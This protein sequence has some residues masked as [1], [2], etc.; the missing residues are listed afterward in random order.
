MGGHPE[1]RPFL[2]RW[3]VAVTLGETLGF[4][5]V[6]VVGASLASSPAPAGVVYPVMIAAGAVEGACLGAGQVVGFGNRQHLPRAG[7]ASIPVLQ[8]LVL[9][10]WIRPAL[11][12]IPANMAGWSLGLLWTLAPSPFI[13]ERTPPG[14]TA[15][16]FATSGLLM[17]VTVA[18][19]TGLAARK[20]SRSARRLENGR[21]SLV[22]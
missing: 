18:L 4:A 22:H 10:R 17:A 20:V 7:W 8:W 16:V 11:F 1:E 2:V 6:A 5:F 9:R 14:T 3:V 19:V 12:W 21:A 15:A 13:D